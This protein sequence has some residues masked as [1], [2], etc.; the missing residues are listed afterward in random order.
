[1]KEEAHKLDLLIESQKREDATEEGLKIRKYGQA[2]QTIQNLEDQ[3]DKLE[4]IRLLTE[5]ENEKKKLAMY[6]QQ[7]ENVLRNTEYVHPLD[8]KTEGQFSFLFRKFLRK[9]ILKNSPTTVGHS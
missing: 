6:I 8:T 1:M 2:W 4:E 9:I 7:Q 3:L 5:N